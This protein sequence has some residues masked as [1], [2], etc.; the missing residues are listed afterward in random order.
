MSNNGHTGSSSS[1]GGWLRRL[2][3]TLTGEPRDLEQLGDVLADAR[4]RGLIDADVLEMLESVLQVSEIQVRDVMVARSQMVVIHREEPPEKI[5]PVVIE[6]GHSRFP[7]VGEDRDEV[8]GIL[9]AKDLLRFFVEENRDHFDI[10]ECLRPAVFIPESKRLNVLLKEFRVSHNHM[11]IVVDEYGGVSGLL[12]IED[13]LEQIVG[14]IGD[15]YDV[16]EGEGIRKEGDRAWTVPALTR[17][18]EFNEAFGTRFSDEEADTIGGLVLHELGR[19]P[20][21][22]EAIQIGGL[23]LKITRA[24]RR[25][26]ETLRVTTPDVRPAPDGS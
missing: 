5:L 18:E 23:E 3:E 24:D 26:I 19:M 20:R 12:T 16:D 8:V 7:V 25:R 10:R 6:S 13:V 14:D 22:G 9:L 4:E 11:A 2:A 1:G 21:R 15:E 17:I